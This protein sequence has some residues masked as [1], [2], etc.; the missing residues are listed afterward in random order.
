MKE[1]IASVPGRICLLGEHMDWIGGEVITGTIDWRL[2][3]KASEN[4]SMKTTA[5]S[6]DP[7]PNYEE[8]YLENINI[9]S[10]L[11]YIPAVLKIIHQ[12]RRKQIPVDITVLKSRNYG[13]SQL[14]AKKGLASS[15]ALCLGTCAT[16]DALLTGKLDLTLQKKNEYAEIS[17]AAE[18]EVLD[19]N[20]GRMD[21]YACSLGGIQ[22]INCT[23]D[24]SCN[25]LKMI[26]E[27][28]IVLGDS[29][30]EKNTEKILAW[31][32]I[33]LQRKDPLLL[34]GISNVRKLIYRAKMV[35]NNDEPQLSLLWKLINQNQN[36]LKKNFQVSGDCPLSL[37]ILDDLIEETRK[38]G[39]YCSK[40][41]GSGGGGF[42]YA[43][44]NPSKTEQICKAIIDIGG[45][46]HV[47][48][49]SPSGIQYMRA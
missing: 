49:I 10:E 40:L 1:V 18:R 9:N 28:D 12:R 43:L 22:H 39:A 16:Y 14:P 15:A 7:F 11:K 21:Q 29:K 42:M 32:K 24:I 45:I 23:H 47:T 31:L 36:V 17:Y 37:S 34:E 8:I 46:P 2:V 5:G 13:F 38:A 6:F 33:R 27:V 25:P 4:N 48:R 30:T 26:D 44:C 35:L 41:T 20:C 19:I 3:C